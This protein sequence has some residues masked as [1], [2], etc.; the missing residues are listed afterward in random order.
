MPGISGRGLVGQVEELRVE[1][2]GRVERVLRVHAHVSTRVTFTWI[3]QLFHELE[4]HCARRIDEHD[5]AGAERR[6]GDDLRT[7]MHVVAGDLRVE[8]VGEQRA[9][10]RNPSSGSP[11]TSSSY[12]ARVK[13]VMF[14]GPSATSACRPFRHSSVGDVSPAGAAVERHRARRG[15]PVSTVRFATPVIVISMAPFAARPR[16]GFA[17]SGAPLVRTYLWL[18]SL[19][20]ERVASPR[21]GLR[22]SAL[23][24]GVYGERFRRGPGPSCRGSRT[25]RAAGARSPRRARR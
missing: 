2:A 5:P 14:S 16:G 18:P 20:A 11:S 15:P 19:R 24:A 23:G 22:S 4:S 9:T 10:R 3:L 1:A 6:A 25:A 12:T 8:V 13:S 7:P 21:A 17:V